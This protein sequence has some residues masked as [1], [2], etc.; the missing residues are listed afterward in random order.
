MRPSIQLLKA[1]PRKPPLAP[2]PKSTPPLHRATRKPQTTHHEVPPAKPPSKTRP[3]VL[4][5]MGVAMFSISAYASYLFTTYHQAASTSP[6]TIPANHDVS[7]RYRR[8]APSYD[9]DVE[10]MMRMGK[11]RREL[12][13]RARGDV[14]EVS[15]GTGRNIP[16]YLLG[17][18]RGVDKD[19]RASV[20]GC[21]SVTFVDLWGEM[22]DIARWKYE[23]LGSNKEKGR[24][25]VVFLAQD[26]MAPVLPP[27]QKKTK[28]DTVVQSM[29]LCSH[30]DPVQLL[31][32]LGSVTE[33]EG[34]IL[35]L[36]HGRGHYAWVNRLLDD[37]A[38]AHADRHG[39]WWN[40][41]IGE[42]VKESG[43]VVVEARRYHLGTTWEYVL[44][45]RRDG[46]KDDASPNLPA[47]G[48]DGW[49]VWK[50]A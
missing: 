42:I 24:A 33:A 36:E 11:R 44:R 34:R 45:P 14:L 6:S 48:T 9:S 47:A 30:P 17:E 46:E 10:T 16:Y 2:L 31:R 20:L 7:D 43:L 8:T 39:C 3:V 23:E 32:H 49:L 21:R 13:R 38:P 41:D 29:G 28:F 26:A 4:T 27:D 5:V 25:K 1:V 12:V 19:G 50:K 22:V 35:L 40:R 37:L 18:R 15:A